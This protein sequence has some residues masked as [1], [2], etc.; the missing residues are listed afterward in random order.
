MKGSGLDLEQEVERVIGPLGGGRVLTTVSGG[1]DSVA[2]LV[3]LN[4]LGVDVVAAH[5]NFHLRGE[6]SDRDARFVA[7]LCR[8][9]GVELQIIDFDVNTWRREN[10]GSMEMACRQL[11]YDWFDTLVADLKC[12]RILTA[13]HADDNVETLLLNLLRGCGLEGAKGMLPD[14]G[15]VM[16]PLLR[17]HRADIEAYLRGLGQDWIVDSTNLEDEPDRNFLRLR[18]LPL[19][20]ERFPGASRRLA[21]SQRNLAEDFRLFGQWSA[22]HTASDTLYIK[23][24]LAS[25]SPSTLLHL[26]L[27]D[28]AFTPAQQAEMLRESRRPGSGTRQWQAGDTVVLLT[29]DALRHLPAEMPPITITD[30][31]LPLT[32]ALFDS[33]KANADRGTAYFPHPLSHYR[34][35]TP[36]PGERMRISTHASRK[37]SDL[38]AEAGIPL[39]YRSQYPLLADPVTDEPL[40]LPFVRRAHADLLAASSSVAYRLTARR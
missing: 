17:L 37:V 16:R 19:L 25:A 36:R 18:V 30:E 40:W 39:P 3:A 24:V 29:A 22:G 7:G 8:R 33:I 21:R 34:Q 20:N 26:W 28:F 23:D 4:R 11:R 12:A 35:R 31:E 5:C 9:L 6:E 14:N 38:L 27:R 1:A 13:H 32:R 2:L 15:R 10:G